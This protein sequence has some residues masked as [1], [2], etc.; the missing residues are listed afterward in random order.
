MRTFMKTFAVGAAVAAFVTVAASSAQAAAFTI[1]FCPGDASCPANITEASVTFTENL[2]TPD[3]NDYTLALKIVGGVG[4]PAYIDM[5]SFA[6]NT[7]DNV[8]G[9]G[10][11]EVKPTLLSAPDGTA[12]WTIY[13]DNVNTGGCTSDTNNAKEVCAQSG[14]AL[15]GG[16][17]I[18]T[19]GTNTWTFSVDLADDVAALAAGSLVKLRASFITA[20][21]GPG[22]NLS[23]DSTGLCVDRC[24]TPTTS[25]TPTTTGSVPEPASLSLLGAGLLALGR[26]YR[27][28]N[29]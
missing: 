7:A 14:V 22:G 12:N 5:V 26:S 6:I 4:D 29:Q 2:G 15:N 19:N 13:Y 28:R 21:G 20:D 1:N 3:A 16:N 11:Y 23:P 8:T 18:A 25:G 9:A 10:G 27:R 17:G 24:D